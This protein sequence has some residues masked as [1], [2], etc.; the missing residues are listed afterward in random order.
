MICWRAILGYLPTYDLLLQK[1]F[2]FASRCVLCATDVEN[3]SHLFLHCPFSSEI[4]LA[5]SRLFG[6]RIQV[7]GT[8]KNLIS[9]ATQQ[10]LSPQ[11]SAL[12]CVAIVSAIYII[13]H[14]R[15]ASIFDNEPPNIH[16]ALRH[17]WRSIKETDYFR[18]GHMFNNLD[19]FRIL[20]LLSIQGRSGRAPKMILVTWQPPPSG[21]I[22][23]N[24]DGSYLGSPGLVGAGGIF[25]T[26]SGFPHGAFSF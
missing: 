17:V 18:V 7:S 11:L 10:S 2:T 9:D 26:S 14:V 1:G 16:Q 20:K 19:E 6:R 15:N 8:L 4:W 22:K 23:V 24:T 12:W 25:R 13:W 5:I 21:W 3:H